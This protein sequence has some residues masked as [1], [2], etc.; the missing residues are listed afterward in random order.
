MGAIGGIRTGLSALLAAYCAAWAVIGAGALVFCVVSPRVGFAMLLCSGVLLG[1]LV[2][3]RSGDVA[4]RALA[5]LPEADPMVLGGVWAAV[6]D[7]R[8]GAVTVRRSTGAR[9]VVVRSMRHTLV[10]LPEGVHPAE[11]VREIDSCRGWI[12]AWVVR[13]VRFPGIF[14]TGLRQSLGYS[15]RSLA[16]DP[17]TRDRE[18]VQWIAFVLLVLFAIPS[19]V[20]GWVMGQLAMLLIEPRTLV[21]YVHLSTGTVGDGPL[22]WRDRL[23]LPLTWHGRSEPRGTPDSPPVVAVAASFLL[24][25][26]MNLAVEWPVDAVVWGDERPVEATVARIA[27]VGEPRGG[28]LTSAAPP[29]QLLEVRLPDR[30]I[31]SVRS[32][33]RDFAVGDPV[34]LAYGPRP[35]GAM[36]YR[37]VPGAST[38]DNAVSLVFGVGWAALGAFPLAYCGNRAARARIW[39]G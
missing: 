29:T 27:D 35:G 14:V 31:E 33:A 28:L 30:G 15:R 8:I 39:G 3:R 5:S 26:A 4:A 17:Y 22:G 37:A 38:M 6:G 36:G 25:M 21:A 9:V 2:L 7:R 11:A 12:L 19:I 18:G 24:V 10:V 1:P 20:V 32:A 13:V 34:L 16:S 23:L